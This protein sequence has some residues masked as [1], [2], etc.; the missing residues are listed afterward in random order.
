MREA[1]GRAVS[2][3]A[4]LGLF[5]Y[6][7]G[8][9][10]VARHGRRGVAVF[11]WEVVGFVL[12]DVVRVKLGWPPVTFAPVVGVVA[13]IKLTLVVLAYRGSPDERSAVR[14]G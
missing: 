1:V 14:S 7:Y 3:V 5:T 4:F 11:T 12:F 9:G 2:Y 6:L 8:R 13:A 10:D